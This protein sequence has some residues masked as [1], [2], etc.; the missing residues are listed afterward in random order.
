VQVLGAS[1]GDPSTTEA[2][3]AT[4][5]GDDQVI[6]IGV[7]RFGDQALGDLG[8]VGVCGVDEVNPKLDGPPEHAAGFLRVLGFA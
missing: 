8:A 7:E 5:G 1:V 2:C 6:W 4:L 3:Q